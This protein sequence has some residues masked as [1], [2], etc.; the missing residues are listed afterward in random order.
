MG[1]MRPVRFVELVRPVRFVELVRPVRLV[2]LVQ[3][4]RTV[5]CYS[6]FNSCAIVKV[7]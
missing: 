2:F 3:S 5:E 1:L 6:D 4:P 7:D